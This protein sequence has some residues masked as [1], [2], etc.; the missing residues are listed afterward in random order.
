MDKIVL[1]VE[2][3]PP[4]RQ[5]FDI[6]RNPLFGH[7]IDMN[8]GRLAFH[9]LALFGHFQTLPSQFG[10]EGGAPVAGDQFDGIGLEMILNIVEQ[11]D[12]FGIDRVDLPLQ[13]R[14]KK[15][16]DFFG[17]GC[18]SLQHLA[19]PIIVKNDPP[20]AVR[21]EG[22]R[23]KKSEQL[24]G[25]SHEKGCNMKRILLAIF[26]LIPGIAQTDFKTGDGQLSLYNLHLKEGVSVQYRRAD[27]SYDP[28][29]VAQ[30]VRLLRC[31]ETQETHDIPLALLDL[32]D[33]IQDHFGGKTVQVISGYRSPVLNEQ[34]R[35]TG[36]KVAKYS[37][38]MEGR[39]I[40]IRIPGVATRILRDYS[41][42]L[43]KG[44]VGFY[45]EN[46]FVHVDV[47]RLRHW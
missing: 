22:H 32:L 26:L 23:R 4:D 8:I 38:H 25:H 19:T 33:Q 37:L 2:S 29:A 47:G 39:A 34:L 14:M 18:L 27:G 17:V 9:M 44:G 43:A 15:S 28:G 10:V 16:G 11:I 41:L 46:Q 1:G 13:A 20:V 36:H 7:L 6:G 12:Q 24:F 31:R 5:F 35:K 45:P 3:Y 30:I 21:K 42:S 40:D